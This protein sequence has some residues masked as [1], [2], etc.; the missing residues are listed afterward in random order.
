[1][2][3]SRRSLLTS[4]ALIPL[5]GGLG[6]PAQALSLGSGSRVFGEAVRQIGGVVDIADHMVRSVE[7]EFLATYGQNAMNRFISEVDGRSINE[8]LANTT[9]AIR[10]QIKLIATVL[11]TGEVTRTDAS[12]TAV[13]SVP[14]YPWSLAWSSLAFAKAP[15]ICGGPA[16]GHWAFAPDLR[17]NRGNS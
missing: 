17:N 5:A 6:S 10:E 16:F 3:I 9:D 1:M 15:G 7:K 8:V 12:G 14:Y 4:A 11:Y 13:T 2:N